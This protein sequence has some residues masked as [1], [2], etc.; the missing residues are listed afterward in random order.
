MW[1]TDFFIKLLSDKGVEDSQNTIPIGISGQSSPQ[2]GF[3]VKI[4]E[5]KNERRTQ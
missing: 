2:I 3:A 1:L 5:V 4:G